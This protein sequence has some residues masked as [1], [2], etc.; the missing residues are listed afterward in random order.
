MQGPDQF[1][2]RVARRRLPADPGFD[3]QEPAV[4]AVEHVAHPGQCSLWRHVPEVDAGIGAAVVVNHE[5]A[6]RRA[7]QG[8]GPGDHGIEIG[9]G[10]RARIG[11][12]GGLVKSFAHRLL[13]AAE[14]DLRYQ[15]QGDRGRKTE[16]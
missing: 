13:V 1:I 12:H 4:R 10:G 15:G 16:E 14:G 8:R 7:G 2:K 5:E 11:C 6:D 9:Q 3:A